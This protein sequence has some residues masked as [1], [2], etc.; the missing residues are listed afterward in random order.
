MKQTEALKQLFQLKPDHNTE[1]Y[2]SK[3]VEFIYDLG[4]QLLLLT[5][6]FVVH[7]WQ[8]FDSVDIHY[9]G[10][11]DPLD[12]PY[13][14]YVFHLSQAHLRSTVPARKLGSKAEFLMERPLC[15][16]QC[17]KSRIDDDMQFCLD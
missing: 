6:R 17:V 10:R 8:E 13:T 11:L 3:T 7:S 16:D 14:S 1:K 5:G 12:R 9:T 15:P 2:G 4:E